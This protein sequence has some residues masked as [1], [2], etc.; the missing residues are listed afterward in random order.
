MN[1]HESD[2]PYR[3]MPE[4]GEEIKPLFGSITDK[5]LRDVLPRY[6]RDRGGIRYVEPGTYVPRGTYCPPEAGDGE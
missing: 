4:S 5:P 1:D 6:A 2:D 3:I